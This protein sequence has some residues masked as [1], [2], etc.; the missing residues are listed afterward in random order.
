MKL[1][2]LMKATRTNVDLL[3]EMAK[4]RSSRLLH[5]I[6]EDVCTTL[7]RSLRAFAEGLAVSDQW[8]DECEY[9]FPSLTVFPCC[10]RVRRRKRG[11][12]P[13]LSWGSLRL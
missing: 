13:S 10:W 1:G 3:V 12:L 2:H 6:V 11:H 5:K 4:I 7:S 9:S 8:D